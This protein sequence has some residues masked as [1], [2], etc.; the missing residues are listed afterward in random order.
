MT[1]RARLQTVSP[2]FV[3]PD[4]VKTAEYYRDVLGFEILGYFLDPPVFAMVARDGVELHIGKIDEGKEMHV[5]ETV[6]RGLGTDAYIRVSDIEQ[7]HKELIEKNAEIVEGPILR[8]YDMVE[9]T[10]RDCN[11]FQIVFGA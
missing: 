10:I 6:R 4:V 1:G 5:N 9:I 11:G 2:Q 8:V 3:V 7:L